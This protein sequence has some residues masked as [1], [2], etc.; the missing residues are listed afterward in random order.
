MSRPQIYSLYET[1]LYVE[2]LER[3]IE[4]YRDV[5]GLTHCHTEE[6]RRAAFFW[7]GE[8]R[9]SMLGVWERAKDQIEIRHFAF[10]VKPQAV[11]DS[12]AWL[13]ESGLQPYNFFAE[14]DTEP[15]V[16]AWV[17]AVAIYFRD[18]DGHSLEFIGLLDD[19]PAAE[20]GVVRYSDWNDLRQSS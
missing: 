12:V 5:L 3:S 6:E 1:H 15:M 10:R 17:P 13:L 20:R 2:S 8:D 14:A 16:F 11:L 7:I 18:P 9:Q 19:K 4:F